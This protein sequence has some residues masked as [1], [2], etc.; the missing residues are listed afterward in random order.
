MKYDFETLVD[1]R[2]TSSKWNGMLGYNP[3]MPEDIIPLSVADME[4]KNPP[5][6]INAIKEYVD[7]IILGYSYMNNDFI[8]AFTGWMK[9]RHNY[10][11]SPDSLVCTSGVVTSIFTAVKTFTKEHDGVVIMP[12]VYRPFYFAVNRTNRTLIECNLI[13][14]NGYY[15]IDFDKLTEIF[16]SGKAKALIFCSPHNPVGR[17]WK[18]EELTQLA[19]LCIKYNVFVIADEIHHDIIM[20]GNTHTILETVDERLKDHLVTCS[21]LSKT[22]N[23]AGL[24]LS[25]SIIPNKKNKEMFSEELEKIPQHV[26]LGISYR[27]YEVAYNKGE[28]WLNE[29]LHVISDNLHFAVDYINKN[30]PKLKACY[31]EGTYLLWIDFSKLNLSDEKLE[32]FLKDDAHVFLTQG[33]VFGPETGKGFAR[34]N[35]AA[36]KSVIEQAL[37]RLKNSIEKLN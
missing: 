21:S 11:V 12:P 7:S 28:E 27:A 26:Y 29:A 5:E 14:N 18:K 20:E 37:I 32:S 25:V 34:M 17:V 6:I 35:V 9:R 15:T 23:L 13:N 22:F 30:I 3:N 10:N 31:P 19:E 1:R 16:K 8:Q 24:G 4:F 33:N 2:K 36:P